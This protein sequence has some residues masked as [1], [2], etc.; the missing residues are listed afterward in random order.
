MIWWVKLIEQSGPSNLA[1]ENTRMP[2]KFKLQKDLTER[3]ESPRRS[4][5]SSDDDTKDIKNIYVD[6]KLLFIFFHHD[7]D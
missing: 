6:S 3:V 7:L 5:M 2:H 1:E 4:T